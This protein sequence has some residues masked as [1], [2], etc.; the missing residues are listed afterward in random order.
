[1]I[2]GKHY[3]KTLCIKKGG[4]SGFQHLSYQKCKYK[5]IFLGNRR[6]SRKTGKV[7]VRVPQTTLY[8]TQSHCYS[9]QQEWRIAT[10]LL[11]GGRTTHSRFLIPLE[12][13]EHN[14]CRIT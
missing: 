1:M 10:L 7:F 6:T 12:L 9:E 11:T 13:Q 3:E 4:S 5:P 14:T 2:I 8:I